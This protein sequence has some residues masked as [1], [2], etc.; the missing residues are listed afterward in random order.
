[1]LENEA[2]TIH[3]SEQEQ[4]AQWTATSLLTQPIRN[5]D[6]RRVKMKANGIRLQYQQPKVS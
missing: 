3:V 1:M 6:F 2:W 5:S 4:V